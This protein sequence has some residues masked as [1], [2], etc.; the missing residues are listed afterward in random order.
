[1]IGLQTPNIISMIFILS[2]LIAATRCSI[3]L[4]VCMFSGKDTK[5]AYIISVVLL[6]IV[7]TMQVFLKFDN[8][9][10]D[11]ISLELQFIGLIL[12]FWSVIFIVDKIP[13]I[14]LS[15]KKNK[16]KKIGYRLTEEQEKK[17]K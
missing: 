6:F 12:Q 5:L 11:Q 16:E 3:W 4:I 14:S 1:M 10:Y 8:K 17:K 15:R 9:N 13:F 7:F 2:Y